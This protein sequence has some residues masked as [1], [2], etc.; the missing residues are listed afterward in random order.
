M[1]YK[2]EYSFGASRPG[3][4]KS[5]F[6]LGSLLIAVVAL[7][8]LFVI[9]RFVLRLLY[10]IAP[11]LLIATAI[12]DYRVVTGYIS[13]LVGMV[14]KNTLLGIGAIVLSVI[15]FPIVTVG[16]FGKA[17]LNRKVRQIQKDK[18][19]EMIRPAIGEYVDFE[20]VK[21]ERAMRLPEIER[22]EETRRP[23]KDNEYDQFFK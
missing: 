1:Q 19:Q 11:F 16:L 5:P 20:E 4:G 9:A 13:W 17:L 18:E 15:G 6:N 22:R 7:I 8:M 14:K 23:N 12:I 21:K 2:R 3:G 10:F